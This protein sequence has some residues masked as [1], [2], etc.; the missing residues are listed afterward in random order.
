MQDVED[1][2]LET[3]KPRLSGRVHIIGLGNAGTFVAHSLASRQSPP[4]ITLLMH[5]PSFYHA[6][7]RKKWSLSV[8]YNG[9]DD[10][11]TGFD[12]EVL[13][14]NGWHKIPSKEEHLEAMNEAESDFE[15]TENEDVAHESNDDGHIECLIVCCRSHMTDNAIRRVRH[16]LTSDSTI[17]LIQNGMGV[18][19]KLNREVFPDE[20]NRPHYIQGVLSHALKKRDAFQ[21]SHA[22]VGTLILSPVVT[23]QTPL[24]EAEN[25]THWAPTT[26]YLLRLLTLTPSLVAAADTPA[27]ILQYQL[28]RLAV[29][30]VLNP[31]TAIHECKNSE[32]LYNYPVTRTMRLLLFEISSVICALPELR[33]VPGIEDRFSP[34]RLRRQVMNV[35]MTHPNNSGSIQEDVKYQQN[36]EIEFMNGWIVDR[37]EE[38]GIKCLLNYMIKQLVHSKSDI[39]RQRDARAVPIDVDSII[40]SGDP[41]RDD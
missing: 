36:T 17:L 13:Y 12:V 34:E 19:E 15:I 10:I 27:G 32:L 35:A 7:R 39:I 22:N 21:V 16:R 40:L 37:G 11:K 9:L 33:G 20:T 41:A 38:L 2:S 5:Q 14:D 29:S 31:L 30:C 3:D 23:A 26:K 1:V 25:D 18:I 8:N 28:E 24:I 4:P 6:F